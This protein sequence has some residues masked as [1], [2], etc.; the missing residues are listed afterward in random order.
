[1]TEYHTIITQL[2]SI[3]EGKYLTKQIKDDQYERRMSTRG[4]QLKDVHYRQ[5]Q[6]IHRII[7]EVQEVQEIHRIAIYLRVVVS[8]P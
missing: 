2:S 6:M 7:T 8:D 4:V 1:M 5:D 3:K